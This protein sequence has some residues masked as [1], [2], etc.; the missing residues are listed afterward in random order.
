MGRKQQGQSNELS[1]DI[2]F[3][4]VTRKGQWAWI[5]AKFRRPL[6]AALEE[7][8]GR[9]DPVRGQWKV[10]DFVLEKA[11]RLCMIHEPMFWPPD[12]L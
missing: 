1:S 4:R 10:H 11:L 3:Y 2:D 7:I 9:W 8:G 12:E 5:A 6:L